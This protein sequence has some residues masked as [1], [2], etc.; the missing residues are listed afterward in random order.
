MTH[1]CNCNLEYYVSD[2]DYCIYDYIIIGI[3]APHRNSLYS[4]FKFPD[5]S[6]WANHTLKQWPLIV[7]ASSF[8]KSKQT[9]KYRER[10]KNT[11]VLRLRKSSFMEWTKEYEQSNSK[12]VFQGSFYQIT[13]SKT[14]LQNGLQILTDDQTII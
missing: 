7:L 14:L 5:Y 2:V 10:P 12:N 4:D 3:G 1:H 8:F 6:K 11:T 13:P 9:K